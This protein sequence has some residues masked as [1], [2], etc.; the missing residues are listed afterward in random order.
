MVRRS[1][2]KS[3]EEAIELGKQNQQEHRYLN[4]CKHLHINLLYP[5][6]VGRMTGLPIG[7]HEIYCDYY[8]GSQGMNVELIVSHVIEPHC[9]DCPFHEKEGA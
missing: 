2:D 6:E 7:P 1:T 5:S 3:I 8:I 9:T 4:W